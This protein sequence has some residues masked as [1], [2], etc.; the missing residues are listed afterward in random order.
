MKVEKEDPANLPANN[1]GMRELGPGGV[2]SGPSGVR[3]CD[4]SN[5][6]HPQQYDGM[7]S[8]L[9]LFRKELEVDE[10]RDCN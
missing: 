4:A 10:T 9:A 8:L 7:P 1:Q 3:A 6:Y 5:G 2:S